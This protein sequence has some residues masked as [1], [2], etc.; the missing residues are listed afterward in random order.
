MN[1]QTK[2]HIT[3][4]ISS[5]KDEGI[6]AILESDG[7]EPLMTGGIP[8]VL[9]GTAAPIMEAI[10][11]AI[12]PRINGVIVTYKQN[13]FQRNVRKMIEELTKRVETVE[14]N[15][16][17]LNNAM[18]EQYR[19]LYV[20]MLLDNVVDERQEKKIEWSVNGFVN[21]MTNESNENVLQIF[22]DT[23]TDLTVLDVDTLK[24]C[25]PETDIDWRDIEEKYGIDSDRLKM[26][27]EKLVRVGLL[28][29]KNDQL[30]D[31]NLDEIVDYL[32][33]AETDKKRRNPKGVKLP[34][35]IKKVGN[36]EIY[37]ISALGIDFLKSIGEL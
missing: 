18:Q 36:A 8:L 27:K 14:E 2:S 33:E 29:R 12:A 24:M 5:I 1:E 32:K 30:R 21:M 19:G 4:I 3:D 22:F 25:S 23:L 20:E 13:R 7:F 11:G 35:T 16:P 34:N 37:K 6:K 10:I 28:Y 26:V 17:R 15:Y 9:A 31:H